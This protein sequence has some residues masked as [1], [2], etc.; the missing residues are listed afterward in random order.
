[1]KEGKLSSAYAERYGLNESQNNGKV[2]WHTLTES[3]K[4]E[5]YDMKFGDT[6]IANIPVNEII[7]LRE[8]DHPESPQLAESSRPH[9][10][11]GEA[12]S[13]RKRAHKKA[14]R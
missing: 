9:G 2:V 3:G 6:I 7:V 8:T 5:L 14:R 1:V 12:H 11:R 4:M 13:S 10:P